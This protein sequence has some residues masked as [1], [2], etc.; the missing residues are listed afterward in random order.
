MKTPLSLRD[1]HRGAIEA[2]QIKKRELEAEVK[3]TGA[4]IEQMEAQV[5]DV[6]ADLA[7]E[8]SERVKTRCIIAQS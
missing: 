2:L 6:A 3:D 4:Q 5:Q 8:L 1:K 7:K